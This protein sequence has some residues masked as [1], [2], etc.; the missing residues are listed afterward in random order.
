MN[1]SKLNGKGRIL[2]GLLKND[3]SSYK[4]VKLEKDGAY[5][6]YQGCVPVIY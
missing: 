1:G 2:A 6:P 3:G 4:D 5:G